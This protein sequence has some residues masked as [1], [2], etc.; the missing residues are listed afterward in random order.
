MKN[1]RESII[2]KSVV[3]LLTGIFV[4][5][6][7]GNAILAVA[8]EGSDFYRE[9]KEE[10]L[11]SAYEHFFDRYSALALQAMV[12]ERDSSFLDETNFRYGIVQADS[13]EELSAMNLA[14]ESN[15]VMRNF[16]TMPD[17]EDMHIFDFEIGKYTEFVSYRPYSYGGYT[18][19]S[20]SGVYD[21]N[22]RIEKYVYD[23]SGERFYCYTGDKYY[24]IEDLIIVYQGEEL[25][26]QQWKYHYNA[27]SKTYEL[28]DQKVYENGQMLTIPEVIPSEETDGTCILTINCWQEFSANNWSDANNIITNVMLSEENW[29]YMELYYVSPYNVLETES[30]YYDDRLSIDIEIAD[31]SSISEDSFGELGT[32]RIMPGDGMV[33]L[34]EHEMAETY[35]VISY[36]N[37]PLTN[38]GNWQDGDLFVKQECLISFAYEIRYVVL[39]MAVIFGILSVISFILLCCVTGHAKGKEGITQGVFAKVP[40]ELFWFAVGWVDVGLI[41]LAVLCIEG[42]FVGESIFWVVVSGVMCLIAAYFTE[43]IGMDFVRRIKGGKWWHKTLCYMFFDFV[44]GL[45]RRFVNLTKEHT[46]LFWKVVLIFGA[47]WFV[48][49]MVIGMMGVEPGL[50]ILIW[51]LI[52][53]VLFV[54]LLACVLQMT[55]LKKAGENIVAGNLDYQVDTSKMMFEFKKHGE[56][57]N[58]IRSGM[59][60]EVEARMKSEH[61]KTELITNVSHDIKTPLTSI[62]N[63]VDLLEKEEIDNEKVN[64][65][66]AVLERQSARLKKLIEDLMEASKASTGN[67]SVNFE[68]LEAGVFLVQTVGEFEEKTMANRLELIIS[69]PEEPLYIMADGRHFWRVIDNLMNNIC[70]YAQPGT[71]VYI[72]LEQADGKVRLIFRNTSRYALNISS[73]ELMERFVRGDSSRNTEGSGLGLSI[74]ASLMELMHANMELVVDGDLFKVVLTFDVAKE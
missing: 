40:L 67:L 41:A 35:Y 1:W 56:N 29:D 10:V 31:L 12:E 54:L 5:L 16:T 3:F 64:E 11:E 20:N 42:L 45:W 19:I 18:Y 43:W 15:Y 58:S 47:I 72:N 63:Y 65:Y 68:K 70:K 9:E 71:R 49:F 59:M 32:Y 25:S 30:G 66:L 8:F 51:I 23:L 74:A 17:L 61:F 14:D 22:P 26:S 39:A 2:V 4:L 21:A 57:L 60:K 53:I 55:E 46:S 52:S 7:L 37:T 48:E 6:F 13:Y 34:P 73:E 33:Y 69:K 24:L 62:I 27:E 38:L 36:L 28:V 44:R 50:A